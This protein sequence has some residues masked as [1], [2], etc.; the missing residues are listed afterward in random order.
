MDRDDKGKAIILFCENSAKVTV[1]RVTVNEV[2][3]DV[4]G[5][6]I[7]APLHG[8]ESGAQRLWTGESTRVEFEAYDLEVALFDTLVAKAT[9]FHRHHFRQ[10]AREI[11]YMHTRAPVDVRRIFVSQKEDFH[12]RP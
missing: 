11:A 9:H 5:V 3:I 12:E 8:A 1:P 4:C 7:D 10:F 6:E 2:G